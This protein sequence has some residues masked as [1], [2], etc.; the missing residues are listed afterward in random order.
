MSRK[1]FCVVW[2]IYCLKTFMNVK[3]ICLRLICYIYMYEAYIIIY[4]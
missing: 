1:I 2:M 4:S 3:E